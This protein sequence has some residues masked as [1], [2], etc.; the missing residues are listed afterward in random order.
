MGKLVGAIGTLL[1]GVAAILTFFYPRD[2]GPQPAPVAAA[3][4]VPQVVFPVPSSPNPSA[5][6]APS[7]DTPAP[8]LAGGQTGPDTYVATY[9]D[10]RFSDAAGR[11]APARQ[12]PNNLGLAL[13]LA[14]GATGGTEVQIRSVSPTSPFYGRLFADDIVLQVNQHPVDRQGDPSQL[15]TEAYQR[16]GRVD[17]LVKRASAT[18]S[19]AFR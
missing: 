1:L 18:Y 19:V 4:P 5:A 7:A 11:A 10:P 14:P 15:L 2:D 9:T 12:I 13:L 8:E 16:E 6:P 17:L 3:A